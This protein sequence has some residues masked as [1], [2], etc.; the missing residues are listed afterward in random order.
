MAIQKLEKNQ[1][2]TY[3][4][5]FSR[6][7]IKGKRSDY[8]QIHV[9]SAENGAQPETAWLPLIGITYDAKSD[10]LEVAV[11][12]MDHL[13]YHPEEVYVDEEDGV[14]SSLEIVRKD[15]TKEIIELR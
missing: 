2:A 12:N 7:F 3:F 15:G 4:D 1:W 11:E 10:M 6:D 5:T 9:L 13:V 8:A 14:L